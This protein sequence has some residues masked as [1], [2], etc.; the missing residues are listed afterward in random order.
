MDSMNLLLALLILLAFLNILVVIGMVNHVRAQTEQ[1]TARLER[2]VNRII[3]H[4][5]VPRAPQDDDS[6]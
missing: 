6:S 5:N 3:Q 2:K 4:L 1:R